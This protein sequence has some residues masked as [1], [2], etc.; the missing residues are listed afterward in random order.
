MLQPPIQKLLFRQIPG[1]L[2]LLHWNKVE[3]Q[4]VEFKGQILTQKL[5]A[6]EFMAPAP[7]MPQATVV[8]TSVSTEGIQEDKPEVLEPHPKEPEAPKE[9]RGRPKV[10]VCE[11]WSKIIAES[12][13]LVVQVINQTPQ[14]IERFERKCRPVLGDDDEK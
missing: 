4:V 12:D 9:H 13:D 11:S 2:V 5:G 10:S 6:S 1:H 14:V 7:A 8:T 3:S